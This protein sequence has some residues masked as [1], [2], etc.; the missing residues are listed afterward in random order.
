[1]TL[2]RDQ[3]VDQFGI[4]FGVHC[5]RRWPTRRKAAPTHLTACFYQ[6]IRTNRGVISIGPADF[7]RLAQPVIADLYR[8]IPIGERPEWKDMAARLYDAL[9]Q[10]GV[11]ITLKPFTSISAARESK[12]PPQRDVPSDA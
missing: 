1:M 7:A 5:L 12:P 8:A 4:S 2:N 6:T 10:A 11:E 9:D 3:F